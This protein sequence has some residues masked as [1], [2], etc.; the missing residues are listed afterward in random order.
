MASSAELLRKISKPSQSR[1][2]EAYAFQIGFDFGTSFSKCIY[3]DLRKTRAFVFTAGNEKNFLISSS[4]LFQNGIFS[5]N[6]GNEQYPQHGLWHIKMAVNDLYDKNY[7][8][9][10]LKLVSSAGKVISGSQE[11]STFVRAACLFYLSRTLHRI[12]NGIKR[13]F[14][15]FGENQGDCMYVNMAIP[16]SS[17]KKSETTQG[18]QELLERAWRIADRNEPLSEQASLSEMERLLKNGYRRCDTCHVYPEISANIQ[19]FRI[20]PEAV[21]DSSNIYLFTDVGAGTMDQCCL[22]F[23]QREA[24]G[25]RNNYLS[26]DVFPLGS[27]AIERT[28]QERFGG[29]IDAWCKQKEQTS[30]SPSMHE[31][32]AVVMRR[33]T[34][35]TQNTTLRECERRLYFSLK[36]SKI[37][38]VFSG[39]GGDM[40]KPY[41]KGVV[42][43]LGKKIR[44]NDWRDHVIKLSVPSDIEL[45]YSCRSWM[46]RLYVA[47]GLS[48]EYENLPHHLLVEPLTQLEKSAGT[49]ILPPD[50]GDRICPY[51]KGNNP[52]CVH[53]DG[54]GRI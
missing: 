9:P 27:S 15:D 53:C 21:V 18:F 34:D 10:S 19:A 13:R 48:F 44:L 37:F 41:Q 42:D 43:A 49:P 7:N 5:I 29:S 47:Y 2:S 35:V 28:C 26:A 39:G 31:A 40:L 4:I 3:R 36:E 1:R 51:C 30:P 46:K 12:R 24:F 38:L 54:F 20:S 16:V 32:I 17:M 25:A 45:P 23:T 22:T 8:S 52:Q 14:P 6:T 11:Q 33:V 50:E